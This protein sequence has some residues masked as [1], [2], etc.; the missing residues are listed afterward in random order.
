M[1]RIGVSSNTTVPCFQVIKSKGYTISA[2]VYYCI[3]IVED[4]TYEFIAEKDGNEFIGDNLEEVLGLITM[5]EYRGQNQ[6]DWRANHSEHLEY[7]KVLDDSVVFDKDGN[8]VD[9]NLL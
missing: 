3:D 9:E 4:G 6:E 7:R 1:V 5:W 2:N 8:Q